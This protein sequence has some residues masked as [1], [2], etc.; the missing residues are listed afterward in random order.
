MPLKGMAVHVVTTQRKVGDK[1]YRT[2]LLRHSYREGDQVKTA[3]VA[4]ISSLPDGVIELIK[5]GLKGEPVPSSIARQRVRPVAIV[6][7]AETGCCISA[8]KAGL[9][10]RRSNALC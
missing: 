2:H 5:L 7:T 6:F 4:N 8:Y 10:P 3:T 1:V 9:T